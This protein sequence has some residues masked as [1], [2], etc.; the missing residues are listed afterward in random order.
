MYYLASISRLRLTLIIQS[1]SKSSLFPVF[2]ED[3]GTQL[4]LQTLPVT[5]HRPMEDD[6]SLVILETPLDQRVNTIDILSQRS[7]SA[8]SDKTV[9]H[10]GCGWSGRLFGSA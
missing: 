8:C 6:F 10:R 1:L 5:M 3:E 2:I 4:G 9:V 7:V